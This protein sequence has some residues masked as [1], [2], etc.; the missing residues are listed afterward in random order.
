M[1]WHI[2]LAVSGLIVGVGACSSGTG[3]VT[4]TYLRS[5]NASPNAP[6]LDVYV[7]GS[8]IVINLPY[9]TATSY[10]SIGS[11]PASV[12]VVATGDS[13]SIL[14]TTARFA[15]D[16]S[17]SLFIL[18]PVSTLG[19]LILTD[20]TSAPTDSARLRFVNA[21]P[22]S[23]SVDVYVKPLGDSTPATPTYAAVAF[24]SATPYIS[25][26]PIPLEVVVTGAGSK[27]IVVDDTLATVPGGAVRT[28]VAL[29]QPGGGTPITALNL[30][31]PG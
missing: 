27:T 18:G 29:D 25:S 24:K 3:P 10:I 4:Q 14:S 2:A 12:S 19:A 26:Q 23:P 17:Y 8:R 22:S 28:V 21:S 13:I 30:A 1:R 11:G 16:H 9:A 5:V 6:P 7:Y 15:S 20:S 31:N